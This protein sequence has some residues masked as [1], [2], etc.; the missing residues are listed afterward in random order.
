MFSLR[1]LVRRGHG[2]H[3]VQQVPDE[4]TNQRQDEQDHYHPL[5]GKAPQQHPQQRDDER[6]LRRRRNYISNPHPLYFSYVRP[7]ERDP[8]RPRQEV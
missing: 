7:E 5:T 6:Q 2:E 3:Q 8:H 4:Q 1:T